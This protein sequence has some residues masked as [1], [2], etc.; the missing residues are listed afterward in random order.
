[1]TGIGDRNDKCRERRIVVQSSGD[2]GLETG[3]GRHS[4]P[5]HAGCAVQTEEE[6]H[7]H[8]YV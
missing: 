7:V 4:D 5:Q 2:E 3:T 8:V 6:V 1:M